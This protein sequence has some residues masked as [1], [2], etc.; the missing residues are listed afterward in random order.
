M[1]IKLNSES[2]K[3]IKEYVETHRL[4]YDD[5]LFK[6]RKGGA[7]SATQ[8]YRVLKEAAVHRKILKTFY[9]L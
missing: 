8:A 3:A 5:Y 6:S 2:R 4:D 9:T 7:I 1:R